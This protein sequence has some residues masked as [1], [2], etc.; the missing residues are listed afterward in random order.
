MKFAPYKIFIPWIM[1]SILSP[2]FSI[3]QEAQTFQLIPFAGASGYQELNLGT[4]SWYLA[5]HGEDNFEPRAVV[6][7]WLT[8]AGYLCEST[9]KQYVVE[10]RYIGQ[11]V[12]P[13]DRLVNHHELI[14]IQVANRVQVPIYIPIPQPR[15]PKPTPSKSAAIRCVSENSALLPGRVAVPVAKAKEALKGVPWQK[16]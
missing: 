8:R 10:L 12:F 11:R 5:F 7:A 3:A 14:P 9:G 2:S 16:P 1:S 4:D 13:E 6:A 15:T